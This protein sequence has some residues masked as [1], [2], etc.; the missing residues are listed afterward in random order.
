METMMRLIRP[1]FLVCTLAFY[2][3][4]LAKMLVTKPSQHGPRET[5]DK[6]QEVIEQKGMTIFKRIDHQANAKAADKEMPAAEVLIFGNP[7]VG[8][9][10]MLCDLRAGLDLPVRVLVHQDPEG[11][12]WISYHNLQSLK[13]TY[14]M[15]ACA[16]V[17]KMEKALQT[18]TDAA[19]N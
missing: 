10:I 17:D 15:G 11:K 16:A 6:L 5:M 19:A 7:K 3:N 2:G 1:F 9:Q 8:T 4:A 12:T 13:E 14:R 18:I